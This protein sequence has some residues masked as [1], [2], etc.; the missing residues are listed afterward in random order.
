[1]TAASGPSVQWNH[2]PEDREVFEIFRRL[3]LQNHCAITIDQCTYVVTSNHTNLGLAEVRYWGRFSDFLRKDDN[4]NLRILSLAEFITRALYEMRI[5]THDT[6]IHN[7]YRVFT[8]N[9]LE[10]KWTHMPRHE[11]GY[12]R[13]IR[14]YDK[15]WH[16]DPAR[17]SA[18]RF[19]F[20]FDNM[21]THSPTSEPSAQVVHLLHHRLRHGYGDRFLD[22]VIDGIQSDYSGSEASSRPSSPTHPSPGDLARL[23][24]SRDVVTPWPKSGSPPRQR[25]RSQLPTPTRTLGKNI[26]DL[27]HRFHAVV[28][29]SHRSHSISAAA[30]TSLAAQIKQ[31]DLHNLNGW[32]PVS[33]SP[34]MDEWTRCCSIFPHLQTHA[35]AQDI[36]ARSIRFPWSRL[37]LTPLQFYSAYLTIQGKGGFLSHDMGLG[38]THTVLAACA[39][40]GLIAASKARV[41]GDWGSPFANRHLPR[42]TGPRHGLQCPSQAQRAGDVICYCVPTGMTRRLADVVKPGA[43]LIQVPIATMAAW[44]QAINAADFKAPAAYNFV[45][46]SQSSEIPPHLRR[47][48]DTFRR[49]FRMGATA[50][51]RTVK[52]SYDLT[53]QSH[54]ALECLGNDIFVISHGDETFFKTFQH[55]PTDLN[56]RPPLDTVFERSTVYG[57]PIGLTF[58]DEAHL[59]G[60]YDSNR[61]PMVMAMCHKWILNADLWL[62]SSTPLGTK[63]GLES[64]VFPMR[65]VDAHLHTKMPQLADCHKDA[66]Y[67]KTAEKMQDFLAMFRDMF[68]TKLVL[69][70]LHSSTFLG[71]AVSSIQHVRP[72]L[73]VAATPRGQ[74]AAVQTLATRSK[75]SVPT[76]YGHADSLAHAPSVVRDELYFV[77]L[78]PAAARLIND[79]KMH[80]RDKDVRTKIRALEDRTHVLAIDEVLQHWRHV[81]RHSPKLHLIL[82]EVERANADR[83]ERPAAT[84]GGGGVVV[85]VSSAPPDLTRRPSSS[86]RKQRPAAEDNNLALKKL[87]IL[88]P[89]VATAVYLYAWLRLEPSVQVHNINPVLYHEDLSRNARARIEQDFQSLDRNRPGKRTARTLIA[90]MAAAATG[91]NLQVANYQILTSPCPSAAELGQAF[92]RTNRAGQPLPVH[93]SILVLDD[94]PIDR[95]NMACLAQREIKSDPYALDAGLEMKGDGQ[96][97]ASSGSGGGGHGNGLSH[98]DIYKI[99]RRR[100]DGRDMEERADSAALPPHAYSE[101]GW[102]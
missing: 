102:I 46:V 39:L 14:S 101:G 61:T 13:A 73:V 88:T 26:S 60:V 85:V 34:S 11:H 99:L 79:G 67:K 64:L 50:A 12:R 21:H 83:R 48:L 24:R 71:Q 15:A 43:S 53:W 94:S 58:I 40:K 78:F 62:V 98:E 5:Q 76:H 80:V 84:T 95:I 35:L 49:A 17:N 65:L 87:V 55:K 3:P 6:K 32:L 92:A 9:G 10:G 54:A 69:R 36:K 18:M 96:S 22:P 44:A 90:T 31:G 59:P 57:A 45:I 52:N 72:R 77:S 41:V 47:D 93:H 66:V 23:D 38:K 29:T 7:H 89:T 16:S 82:S 4:G 70:F 100:A 86:S 97:D 28:S 51:R 8:S 42:A 68:T 30:L 27:N 81:G 63:G 33:P 25:P 20:H 37:Y 2:M 75:E 74:R 56:P 91:M 1:M 19:H